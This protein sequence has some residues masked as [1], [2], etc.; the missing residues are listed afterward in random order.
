[1]LRRQHEGCKKKTFSFNGKLFSKATR[2]RSVFEIFQV[3]V[4]SHQKLYYQGSMKFAKTIE[5]LRQNV[6]I[7]QQII[8]KC[9]SISKC[10]NVTLLTLSKSS[11]NPLFTHTLSTL[12][13]ISFRFFS[14]EMPLAVFCMNI[15]C[16]EE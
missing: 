3:Y 14:E 16:F 12:F 1:M 7:R 5:L 11:N 9:H 13:P 4:I 15:Y 6:F 8:S 2:F 10:Q